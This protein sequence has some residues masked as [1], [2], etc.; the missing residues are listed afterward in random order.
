M[1][2]SVVFRLATIDVAKSARRKL[3]IF[4]HVSRIQTVVAKSLF[5]DKL[6]TFCK[7][8]SLEAAAHPDWVV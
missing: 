7:R 8:Q 1:D 5:L 4:A 3:A 6:K 2:K